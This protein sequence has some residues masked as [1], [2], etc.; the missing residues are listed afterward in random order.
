MSWQLVKACSV[1]PNAARQG[2]S[3]PPA[4]LQ[5]RKVGR[6]K[7]VFKTNAMPFLQTYPFFI[8]GKTLSVYHRDVIPH[9][10]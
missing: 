5:V 3:S 9:A 4:T 7:K 2:F 6:G 8:N 1:P 10:E